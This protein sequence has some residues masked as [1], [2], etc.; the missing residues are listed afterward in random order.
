M[1]RGQMFAFGKNTWRTS[2]FKMIVDVK[3][4]GL[5]Y[6]LERDLPEIEGCQI[7]IELYHNP[8]GDWDNRSIDGLKA[9]IQ[10]Q[11][12]FMEITILFNGEQV[13]TPASECKWDMEDENA[14]Y[15]FNVGTGVRIY[16]LGAYA[17]EETAYRVGCTGVVVSKKRLDINFARND[18]MATC[19][20]YQAIQEVLKQ[21]LD[22]KGKESVLRAL[23]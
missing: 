2:T 22:W 4:N 10:K 12:M 6:D 11:V 23:K 20:I 18:I 7:T 17:K 8:I 3:E 19:L 1:G 14:Y 5:D 13:N 15:L 21:A 16:N 9:N